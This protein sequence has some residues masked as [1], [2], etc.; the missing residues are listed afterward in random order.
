MNNQRTKNFGSK[1]L[2]KV[3]KDVVIG[4]KHGL[5]SYYL[6]PEGEKIPYINISDVSDGSINS[7]TVSSAAIK[8]TAALAKTRIEVNDV[9]ITVK[10]S[11]FKAAIASQNER[12]AIISS[13][14][15]AFKL[16]NDV[17]PELVV[18]Y[19]NSPKGQQ[20]LKSRSAGIAQKFLSEKALLDISIPIPPLEKQK[21]L[22]V[23]LQLSKE[24]DTLMERER[25]LRK[26]INNSVVQSMMG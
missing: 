16:N 3:L 1:I 4:V 26:R 8:E 22:A 12:N 19:L 7:E 6:Q 9:I 17:L 2:N 25:E 24:Y 21:Q 23:Y 18:A 15:I 11:S 13:N 20:E 10:G 14:L 5:S